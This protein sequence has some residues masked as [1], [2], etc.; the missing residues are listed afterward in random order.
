MKNQITI[1][2]R[3]AAISVNQLIFL[4]KLLLVLVIK[5]FHYPPKFNTASSI[6]SL[7]GPRFFQSRENVNIQIR[8]KQ[9]LKKILSAFKIGTTH[10]WEVLSNAKAK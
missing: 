6:L 2:S 4:G 9:G 5:T 1:E 10:F 8:C 7:P 3:L